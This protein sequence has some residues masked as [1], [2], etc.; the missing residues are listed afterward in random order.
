MS[1][2]ARLRTKLREI[3]IAHSAL[4]RRK[5][6]QDRLGRLGELRRERRALMAVIAACVESAPEAPAPRHALS[7][8]LHML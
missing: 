3:N 1:T 6:D 7:V 8:S 5:A 2:I 4:V